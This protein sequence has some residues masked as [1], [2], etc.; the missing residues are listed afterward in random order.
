M[1]HAAARH[2]LD[3]R[4]RLAEAMRAFHAFEM[5]VEMVGCLEDFGEL[6]LCSESPDSGASFLGAAASLRERLSLPRSRRNDGHWA[7]LVARARALA[8]DQ[9]FVTAFANGRNW[10]TGDAVEHALTF[11][12]KEVATA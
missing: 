9:T 5:N 10:A 8:G 6:M 12:R 11:D 4:V 7:Q 2:E 3:R 1:S